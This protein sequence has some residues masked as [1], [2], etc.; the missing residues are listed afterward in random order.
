MYKGKVIEFDL[1]NDLTKCVC[2]SNKDYTVS[3]VTKLNRK[4]KFVRDENDKMF[5][6]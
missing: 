6:N 4:T 5:I 1:T 3:N 2:K